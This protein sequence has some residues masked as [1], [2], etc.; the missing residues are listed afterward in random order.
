MSASHSAL[1]TVVAPL[2]LADISS[3]LRERRLT[4]L[5]HG[6]EER[7]TVLK[8]LVGWDALVDMIHRGDYP[9]GADNI[10]VARESQQALPSAWTTGGKVDPS[11]LEEHLAREYSVIVTHLERHVPLLGSVCDEIKSR[12][13]EASYAGVIVTTGK[14]G[15]I[16]LHYDFEDLIII[17]IDGTK[18]WQIFGPAV[19]DPVRNMPRPRAPDDVPIFDEVLEPG[20]LLFVPAGNWHHCENGPSRSIHVGLFF[21]PPTPWHAVRE[22][23]LGLLADEAFR[24]RLTRVGDAAA[25][26]ALE[27]ELK[28]RLLDRV[29]GLD[30]KS[31]ADR[32]PKSAYNV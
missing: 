22:M 28:T 2:G 1:E 17:Q 26:A 7:R 18:R 15:A 20:D 24:V 16:K 31:F 5:R 21:I 12:F 8:P 3:L 25:L 29:N 23:A 9:Q 27:A 10:R 4:H 6:G 19:S 32:W 13:A 30:L 11:K 14:A